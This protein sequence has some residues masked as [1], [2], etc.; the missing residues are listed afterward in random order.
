MNVITP[1]RFRSICL[2]CT[3]MLIRSALAIAILAL[4]PDVARPWG[5]AVHRFLT[6]R[7]VAHLPSIMTRFV[8]DSTYLSV[9]SVDADQRRVTG[10]TSLFAEDPR[11][12]LDIDDY[13]N[14][15]AIPRDLDSLIRQFGWKRVKQNGTNPWATVWTYDS[16]VARLARGDWAQALVAA[17]DLAHYVADAHQP[18]HATRNYNGQETGNTG[19]HSRYE[20]TMLSS[21][22]YLGEL[23]V[24]PAAVSY[25]GDPLGFAFD[26]LIHSQSCV[27]EI[28]AADNSAKASSGWSGSGTAPASYYA[29]LWQGTRELTLDQARRAAHAIADLWYSAWVDA[30][31]V[32]ATNI[33]AAVPEGEHAV[34]LDQNFPNPVSVGS[35]P[36]H[37]GNTVTTFRFQLFRESHVRLEVFN[38]LGER[39]AVLVDGRKGV[40]QYR[41]PFNAVGL[42]PGLYLGRLRADDASVVVRMMLVR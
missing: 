22:Y 11:H 40:G 4:A 21:Q 1:Q 35:N 16:L 31:L 9:H 6:L 30:G 8:Q 20:S 32:P 38:L 25:I 15:T 34:R 42:P 41:L 33:G 19:I 26:C 12:Y 23:F 13:P 28:L 10:D 5:A 7:A 24:T 14:F 27:A 17:S 18:L 39:V 29:A 2:L 3:R 36:F 37:M